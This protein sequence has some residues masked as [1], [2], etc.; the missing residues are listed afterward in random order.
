MP[1]AAVEQ[2]CPV[3][4]SVMDCAPENYNICATCG[5]EFGVNDVN[6]GIESLRKAWSDAASRQARLPL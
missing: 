1:E 5:T 2:R 4:D 3:C 6:A